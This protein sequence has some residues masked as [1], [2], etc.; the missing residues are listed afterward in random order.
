MS[1][2]TL[3][4]V[5]DAHLGAAPAEDEEAFLAFLDLVPSLGDG[6]LLAGDIYDFWF[7]YHRLIPRRCIRTTAAIVA[8]ARRFPVRML[9][10][11][12]D[13]W[14]GTFW[15]ADAGIE[16]DPRELRFALG[17]RAVRAVHG[18]G[19]HEE[20][21]SAT[22]LNHLLDAPAVIQTFRALPA[23]LGFRIA[24]RFGHDPAWARQHPEVEE[25]AARRQ[26][27]WATGALTA[28]PETAF[29]VMGHTHRA[30]LHQVTPGQW[31]INPGA[32][33]DQHRYALVN[34]GAPRLAQ[35]T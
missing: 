6:L 7:S 29:L 15:T 3:V 12:H 35:F 27:A 32:W 19:L 2:E 28:E 22:F 20:R 31:Y 8:L 25:V 11:N 33:L 1:G 16:F 30:A 21:P 34:G 23:S 4:V 18:D 13:R 17:G 10:G 26:L 24:A 9:G 14:G 5:A